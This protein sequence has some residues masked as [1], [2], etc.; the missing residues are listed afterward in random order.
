MTSTTTIDQALV[1][2]LV[3]VLKANHR[4]KNDPS[5][6]PFAGVDL[7]N[8]ATA[9]VFKSA[10]LHPVLNHTSKGGYGRDLE[11]ARVEA[12]TVDKAD[13][14]AKRTAQ[15]RAR[16]ARKMEL[17][18]LADWEVA[19]D[20]AQ[21]SDAWQVVAPL[22]SNIQK[23]A[24]CKRQWASRY[25]GDVTDDVA[26]MVMENMALLLAK[27]DRDLSVLV[28]AAEQIG[29]ETARTGRVA[30]DQ[31]TKEQKAERKE[32]SKARKWLR[33]VVNNRVT[34]TLVDVYC[35][36]NYLK[37]DN[38]DIIDTVMANISGIGDDPMTARFKA[39]SPPS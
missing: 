20:P 4:A 38:L 10:D 5:D 1:N 39:D 32:L 35:R 25:L 7:K 28:E 23:I 26:A 6:N 12:I 17:D 30:G 22:V 34:G 24:T 18:D 8:M 27:S 19:V 11:I 15:N 16:A 2:N 37:H 3:S 33:G 36:S 13:K 9:G 21:L 14:S 29:S 31:E